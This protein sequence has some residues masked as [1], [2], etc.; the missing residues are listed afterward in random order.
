MGVSRP[1]FPSTEK[2]AMLSRP[3]FDAYTN[4]PLGCTWISEHALSPWKSFGKVD[5]VCTSDSAPRRVS[6]S[7]SMM[8]LPI[9]VIRYTQRPL[10]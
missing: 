6:Q 5:T 7:N 9:S 1:L 2:T 10:G 8:V 3:R 4:L